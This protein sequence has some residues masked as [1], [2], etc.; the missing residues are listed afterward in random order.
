M[1]ADRLPVTRNLALDL[2]GAIGI[3]ATTALVT[4][5]LPTIARR[6][7]VEPLGLAALTAM[8]FVA[9]LLSAFAGRWGPRSGRQLAIVRGLGAAS[10]VLLLAFPLPP[11]MVAVVLVFW[12][13]YAFSTPFQLRQWGALYPPRLVGR[14]LGVVGMARAAAG[15]VAAFG[16][17]VLADRLGVPSVVGAIGGVGVLAAAAYAGQ[18]A[19]SR[20]RA[21]AFS[22]RES[23]SALRSRAVLSRVA[24]AQGFYGG[25]MIA[26][27]PLYALVHVDRLHLSLSEVGVIGILLSG[28][29]TLSF[30][31][32][33]ALSDRFG[34][35]VALR[36][37]SLFGIAGVFGYAVAPSVGVLWAM[38]VLLGASSA[39]IDVGIAAVVSDETPLGSRAAAMAGWN[40]LTGARGIVAAFVT[41]ALIS[42]GLADVTSGLLLSAGVA[43]VGTLLFLTTAPTPRHLRVAAPE[44]DIER[45]GPPQAAL[46]QEVGQVT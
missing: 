2:T 29:T 7:G 14:V 32:W 33:G 35:I 11:G 28:A 23:I 30:P 43:T 40:A 37:G 15:A 8:P 24:L 21:P 13:T 39:S 16:G 46:P 27:I 4:A 12:L 18:Q 45:A 17:G 3:G 10:L 1:T 9:N 26:A 31:A 41:S 19:R 20:E 36:L 44:V 22:A 34:A 5:L 38:A 6:G 42:V 25:G